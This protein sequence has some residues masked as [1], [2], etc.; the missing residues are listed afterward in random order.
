MAIDCN[1]K[2]ETDRTLNK[3]YTKDYA[4]NYKL[5]QKPTQ[6]PRDELGVDKSHFGN[7]INGIK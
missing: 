1:K 2:K 7:V 6:K 3:K 4:K 5:H